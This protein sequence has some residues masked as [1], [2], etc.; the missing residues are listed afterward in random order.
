MPASSIIRTSTVATST[1]APNLR[2]RQVPRGEPA[3]TLKSR[4]RS[5][6]VCL[7]PI[8]AEAGPFLLMNGGNIVIVDVSLAL[9]SRAQA[10]F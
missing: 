6:G 8:G 7:Q 5:R 3:S 9:Y 2:P 4:D 10:V 1:A